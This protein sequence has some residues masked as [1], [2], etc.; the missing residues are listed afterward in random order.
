MVIHFLPLF[1][2]LK[3]FPWLRQK[4]NG[5]PL[6]RSVFRNGAEAYAPD[7]GDGLSVV[8]LGQEQGCLRVDSL[9]LAV[10][11]A[12]RDGAGRGIPCFI[13]KTGRRLN[14]AVF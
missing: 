14:D 6:L 12:D 13:D 8:D 2:L 11:D 10:V 3:T 7:G 1:A 5:V 4:R 9:H